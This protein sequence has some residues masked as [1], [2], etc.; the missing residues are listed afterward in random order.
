MT[1]T[2]E[3]KQK[4]K[5]ND[6]IFSLEKNGNTENAVSVLIALYD[7]HLSLPHDEINKWLQLDD[8][9][10]RVDFLTKCFLTFRFNIKELAIQEAYKVNDI[11]INLIREIM[12]AIA[13]E[14]LPSME[15]AVE[16]QDKMMSRGK[17]SGYTSS[18]TNEIAELSHKIIN[19]PEF[20]SE[21]ILGNERV[22]QILCAGLSAVYF[23]LQ[24]FEMSLRRK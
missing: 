11:D 14:A 18:M 23:T 9:G 19:G 5:I 10:K 22:A 7:L 2:N 24:H 21:H 1:K 16:L 6:L 17:R 20:S 13:T 12:Q 3:V 15:I 8:Q 4:N